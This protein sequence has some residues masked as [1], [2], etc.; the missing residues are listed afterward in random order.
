MKRVFLISV[1]LMLAVTYGYSQTY[2]YQEVAHI[3]ANGVKSKASGGMYITFINNKSM[4]YYSDKDGYKRPGFVAGYTITNDAYRYIKEHNGTFVYQYKHTLTNYFGSYE[5][6]K[7]E[8]Y[9]FSTDFTKMISY[10]KIGHTE[11]R[12]EYKRTNGP[13]DAYDDKIPTF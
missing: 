3:D 1:F 2:Y 9:Y 6:W 7:D 10:Q 12:T 4:C 8:F 13:Q 11:F 5:H